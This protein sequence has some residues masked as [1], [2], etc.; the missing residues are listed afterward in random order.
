MSNLVACQSLTK[1]FG[2]DPL[3]QAIDLIIHPGDRIGLIGPN[4]SG[5]S[6]LLKI[7]CGVEETDQG[8]LLYGKQVTLGYLAQEDVFTEELTASENLFEAMADAHLDDLDKHT[9]VAELLSRAE[10]VDEGQP[11]RLL[12]GGWRKRLAICRALLKSPE[13]LALDE[14]TNHLDIEGITWLENLILKKLPDGPSAYIMVSHDRQFLENCANRI[15]ELSSVYPDGSF[16]VQGSYRIFEKKRQMFIGR[17]MEMETRLSNKVRRENEWLE[18]GPKARTSKARYRIDEAHRLKD[19]LAEV[20]RRNRSSGKVDIEFKG[21]GRK[22]K[23]LLEA[24]QLSK[25][26]G[27]THDS[28]CLFTDLDIVLKPGSRLGLLGRNGCGKSTLMEILSAGEGGSQLLDKGSIITADR[29]KIVHFDQ[30]RAKLDT[31]MSL[32]RALAPEGDSVVFQGRSLHV[33][34]WAKRFLFKADQL[35]TVVGELSGGEQARILI[36]SLMLQPADILLLDEPTNDLDIG[37][38]DV[39]EESLLEFAGALVLVSH[40]RYLLDRVCDRVLGFT[41]KG[42]TRYFADYHQW[43]AAL[44][45]KTE[46]IHA[47]VAATRPRKQSPTEM[48]KKGVKAGRL[49]YLDQREFDQLEGKIEEAEALQTNLEEKLAG[50]DCLADPTKLQECWLQLEEVKQQVEALYS[51]W[52]ELDEKKQG[53]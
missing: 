22:T 43:L 32:R 47:E 48:S 40:D 21:T 36:A 23:K 1:S 42:E 12:S 41:G 10:F 19:E 2:A 37:S 16:Q 45:E 34:S 6:T 28:K 33:V 30:K 13:I 8:S 4:G 24:T 27:D 18:R 14:P 38:L 29:V 5:K 17:Q 52:E 3:F 51:R 26:Y 53:I 9:R 50:P 11:V 39:L 46:P 25:S 44:K 35:E 7:I 31:S 15:V 49:S 20:K